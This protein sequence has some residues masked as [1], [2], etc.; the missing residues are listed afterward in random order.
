MASKLNVERSFGAAQFIY[1]KGWKKI[2]GKGWSK[3]N[4]VKPSELVEYAYS[5]INNI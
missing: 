3:L 5:Y 2:N 1:R 4:N